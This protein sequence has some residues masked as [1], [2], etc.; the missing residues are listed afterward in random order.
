MKYY[1]NFLSDFLDV[2]LLNEFKTIEDW[3]DFNRNNS[4]MLE[5]YGETQFLK[6]VREL[7]HS[8][9]FIT[10]VESEMNIDGLIVDSHGI[11][12]GVSLMKKG[13]LLDPHIDFNWNNRIRMHRAVNLC[14]YFGECDGGEFHVWDENKEN[15]IFE[16]TPLH[17]SAVL[18][19]HSEILSHGVKPIKK[20]NRYTIRQFYYR[21]EA[22]EINPHQSLYWF[23]PKSQMPT[24][25]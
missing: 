11:G 24:N 1:E 3:S 18:F 7:L 14:I 17:N 5:F 20:G 15:I 4:H 10:W 2:D 9:T 19:N 22:A 12:E 21:S 16:K 23:N 25:S 6:K 13:D 8:K